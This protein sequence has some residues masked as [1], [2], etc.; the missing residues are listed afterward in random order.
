MYKKRVYITLI[1][2]LARFVKIP[3]VILMKYKINEFQNFLGRCPDSHRIIIRINKPKS[4]FARPSFGYVKDEAFCSNLDGIAQL[5]MSVNL[6]QK[7]FN[8]P[9]ISDVT[10]WT[11]EYIDLDCERPDHSVPAT[12]I[13][14]TGL[15]VE[16]E[17][18]N[19]WLEIEGFLPG[20]LD[21]TGNG[22]RWLL[23]VPS[24]DLRDMNAEAVML[25]NEQKKEFLRIIRRET[26]T[27]VD[28]G[29][30]EL[31]RITGIPGTMNVKARDDRDRRREL[32]RSCDR[33]EDA[34]LQ[35]YIMNIKIEEK[36]YIPDVADWSGNAGQ[37]LDTIISCDH[38]L[39]TMIDKVA[40]MGKGKRSDYDMAIAH[41]L[42]NWKVSMAD[43]ID[44]LRQF[45]SSK[46]RVRSEYVRVTVMNAY[47]MR[48]ED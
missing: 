28:T 20:Y 9:R 40:I 16:V 3:N 32:F 18:I 11:C 33:I 26:D 38:S 27:N 43:T 8:K 35:D 24:L 7:V 6:C 34:N 17:R 14:L 5:Y 30:G 22:Y 29:V 23:P 39:K 19:N 48:S 4:L 2:K 15:L 47:M 42:R 41:H 46:A 44:I 10:H 1:L 25:L 45:G 21:F 36:E 12:I 31:S 37:I 13:E